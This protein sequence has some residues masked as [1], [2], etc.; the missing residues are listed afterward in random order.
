MKD[1]IDY[2]DSHI[3]YEDL[4]ECV[5]RKRES[6]KYRELRDFCDGIMEDFDVHFLYI[7]YPISQSP[8]HMMNIL[9]ADTAYGRETDPDG[10]YLGYIA[11][12]DYETDEI[13]LYFDAMQNDGIT[14]FKDFS[15]WGYDYT[16]LKPLKGTNGEIFGLLCVD[17]EVLE[18]ENAI[19]D[20]TIMNVALIVVLGTLF[21]G[22]FLW[23]M[24][25]NVTDPIS[26]LEKSVVSFAKVSHDQKDPKKLNYDAPDIHTHNEVESLSNAVEQMSRD[27]KS[28]VINIVDA[29]GKVA[30]MKSKVSHMDVLAYQDALTHVKN[31]AWYDKVKERINGEIKAGTAKFAIIMADLNHLKKINDTYG[32]EHGNDYIF[33][34]CHH[35]CVIFDHSP[36]FRIGGD[37]FV[38]LLEKRDY[39]NRVELFEKVKDTFKM[40]SAD[41]TKDPWERYACALG[42]ATYKPLQDSSMD[43]VF[44]RADDRMYKNKLEVKAARDQNT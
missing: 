21:I 25:K 13:K 44:K 42:M 8:P 15:K 4:E 5:R 28:Y 12:D 24:S 30:D 9:S 22:Y 16:A 27:M 6:E 11:V 31:K 41:E 29:E 32:H 14:F 20:Y 19:R 40:T 7:V 1:I 2:V 38:V 33:G 36:V 10:Y 18:V 34:A 26:S 35:I 43:D 3:D 39:D 17:I 37:E 23:W